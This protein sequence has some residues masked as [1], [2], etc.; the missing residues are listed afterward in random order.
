MERVLITVHGEKGSREYFTG[1]FVMCIVTDKPLESPPGYLEWTDGCTDP[2]HECY[3]F[4]SEHYKEVTGVM[5]I[6]VEGDKHI[7][8]FT[9]ANGTVLLQEVI[10]KSDITIGGEFGSNLHHTTT[11]IEILRY[12]GTMYRTKN[13][14]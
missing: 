4:Y 6:H 1:E 11:R 14:S 10:V 3:F 2:P 5:F 12:E 9:G 8:V 13:D 7:L